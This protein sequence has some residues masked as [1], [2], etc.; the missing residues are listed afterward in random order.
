M[1]EVAK[2]LRML[3]PAVKEIKTY[4]FHPTNQTSGEL[5][6]SQLAEGYTRKRLLMYNASD[7]ASG[8]VYFGGVGVT[9]ETGAPLLKGEWMEISIGSD[10]SCYFVT[11]S[12]G[13]EIRVIE[14]A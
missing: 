8:E 9:Q 4:Q 7:P 12:S 10:L 11:S 2:L 14:L 5:F 13:I 3:A 6:V 1:S